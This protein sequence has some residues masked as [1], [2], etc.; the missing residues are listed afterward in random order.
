[1]SLET[2]LKDRQDHLKFIQDII[3]DIVANKE[4]IKSMVVTLCVDDEKHTQVR[5]CGG[6]NSCIG[7]AKRAEQELLDSCFMGDVI[8]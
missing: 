5:W 8:V 4:E 2:Q 3:D 1:M 7:L 6:I